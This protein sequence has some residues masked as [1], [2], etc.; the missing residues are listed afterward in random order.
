VKHHVRSLK[1]SNIVN[2]EKTYFYNTPLI[3]LVYDNHLPDCEANIARLTLFAQQT[4][5]GGSPP[6]PARYAH[7][8]FHGNPVS[9]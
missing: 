4:R 9:Y 5:G 2:G 8:V 1:M 6:P 7:A 3:T